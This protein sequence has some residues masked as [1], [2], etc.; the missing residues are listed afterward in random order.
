MN[1]IRVLPL[2]ISLLAMCTACNTDPRPIEYGIDQCH[3]CKMIIAD[4]RFGSEL[5]TTK[6]KI[7]KFDAIEC[8]IPTY[9]KNDASEYAHILVSAYNEPGQ[10]IDANS[11]IFLI[12]EMVPS[13]MGRY[14]SAYSS[15]N[16]A[17]SQVLTKEDAL[18]NWTG[19]QKEFD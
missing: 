19:L 17:K 11:A 4:E 10:M 9:Q 7:Y 8:L 1:W 14:L 12:S 16:A 3:A 2:T 13:P 5:V 6:G 18:Y 15:K